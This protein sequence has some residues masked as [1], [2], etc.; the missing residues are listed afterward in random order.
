MHLG[1][2]AWEDLQGMVEHA[3]SPRHARRALLMGLQA[4]ALKVNPAKPYYMPCA[5]EPSKRCWQVN[6]VHLK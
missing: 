3:P 6:W 4:S 5:Q 1:D 2:E